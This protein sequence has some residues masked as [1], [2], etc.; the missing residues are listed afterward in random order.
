M[1]L[2]RGGISQKGKQLTTSFTLNYLTRS[3]IAM[4]GAVLF[5]ICQIAM[6]VIL[7]QALLDR[8]VVNLDQIKL[9]SD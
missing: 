9:Q 1:L 4:G 7:L 3:A 5:S 8:R 2:S 6:I